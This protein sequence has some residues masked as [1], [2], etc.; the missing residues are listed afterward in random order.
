MADHRPPV[1]NKEARMEIRLTEIASGIHQL[2]T[3]LPEMDFSLNQFVVDA[4]EPLLFH[5]GMRSMFPSISATV[6]RLMPPDRMRWI[7]FGHIEADECGSMNEWLNTA[8][9]STVVQGMTGCMVSIGDLA[10][11]EPRALADGDVL[12][13][14]GHALRW[15]DT[16]HV[17]HAW[18]AGLLYDETTRT[19]FSG[20]LFTQMGQYAPST[21]GDIVGPAVA[22]EDDFPGSSSLHPATGSTIRR[23]ASLDVV[24]LAPMHGP[25]FTGDCRAAL[26]DLADDFDKRVTGVA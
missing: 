14:G 20:D 13:I 2:T 21:S 25:A 6:S 3:Y 22:A 1:M 17:P 18:E 9:Q 23:L 7:A 24:T 15:I 26:L 4:D 12:D 16:P 11:R 19:L 5:T 8:P 10:D